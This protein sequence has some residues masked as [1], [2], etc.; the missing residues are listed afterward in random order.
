[1]PRRTF[2]GKVVSNKM[3]KTLIVAVDVPKKHRFYSKDIKVTK[4]F[5]VRDDIGL[6]EGDVVLIEETRPM[7]KTSAWKILE[8]L[9][10]VEVK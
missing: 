8:K 4:R 3:Q 10:E 7:S 2:K 5:K 1:M 6:S 9:E